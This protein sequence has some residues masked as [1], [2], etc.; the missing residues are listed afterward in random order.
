LTKTPKL[1]VVGGGPV[2]IVSAV[3]AAQAGFD[4]ELIEAATEVDTRPR[5]STTHPSTL[6][7]IDRIGLLDRFIAEGLVAREFQFWDRETGT[8]VATFDHDLLRNDTPLSFR[9]SDRAA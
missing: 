9:R 7:M 1:L 2:G 8:L 5:A 6:E 3:A 4:V